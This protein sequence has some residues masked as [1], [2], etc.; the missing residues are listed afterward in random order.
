MARLKS[1]LR[2][3]SWCDESLSAIVSSQ[4]VRLNEWT[5]LIPIMSSDLWKLSSWSNG[6][7]NGLCDNSKADGRWTGSCC[8][9]EVMTTKREL[10]P[11]VETAGKTLYSVADASSAGP[12]P[13]ERGFR[14]SSGPPGH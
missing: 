10:G 12:S 4:T 11:M 5:I 1:V 14:G 9:R 7:N 8:R 2:T 6:G 13:P 3:A